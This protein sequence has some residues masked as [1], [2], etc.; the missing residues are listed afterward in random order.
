M[1]KI[2]RAEYVG[3]RRIRI[4]FNDG[5]EDIFDASPLICREG[6]LLSALHDPDY[7]MSF[8]VALGALCWSNGLELSGASI[9]LALA[10]AGQLTKVHAAT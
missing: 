8:F 3:D 10:E 6:S 7:F 9:H 4:H 1:L 2:V 5:H